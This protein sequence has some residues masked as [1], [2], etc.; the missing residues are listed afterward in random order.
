MKGLVLVISLVAVS[1]LSGCATKQAMNLQ[2]FREMTLGS[3]Y[4]N[5][6]EVEVN[7]SLSQIG[8]S[9]KKRTT[10]CLDVT[11]ERT[12][13]F[14]TGVGQQS[15][16]TSLMDYNPTLKISQQKIELA[17]QMNMEGA[18][19]PSKIPEGGKYTLVLDVTPTSA[20][21]SHLKF[22]YGYFAP[23]TMITTLTGW[24]D[25]TITGCPDLSK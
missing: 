19:T 25:G 3:L 22:Y 12:S 14:Q 18:Y 13:C 21:K 5:V 23:E 8:E 6:K 4:G 20:N 7:R 9:L 10:R 16:N 24:A 2:E 15:C 1:L 11:Y 17:V